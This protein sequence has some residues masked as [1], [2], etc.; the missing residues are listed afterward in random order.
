MTTPG[1][2]D[3]AKVKEKQIIRTQNMKFLLITPE[4][5]LAMIESGI[6]KIN[7][8][9]CVEN[10]DKKDEIIEIKNI[11]ENCLSAKCHEN[12]MPVY[13]KKIPLKAIVM[14]KLNLI[15]NLILENENVEFSNISLKAK[16]TE[17]LILKNSLAQT[18]IKELKLS[19]KKM[20]TDNDKLRKKVDTMIVKYMK[21]IEEL[22]KDN[23][24]LNNKFD[25]AYEM[26][27][28]PRKKKLDKLLSE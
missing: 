1:F 15:D 5:S 19:L 6:G 7:Q 8:N 17:E 27:T 10:F 21:T 14:R 24:K 11:L 13:F 25:I 20:S 28:A 3:E 23:K 12:T 2:T 26:H 4:K 9:C 16:K 22:K 18:S